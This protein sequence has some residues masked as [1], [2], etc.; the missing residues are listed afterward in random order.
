MIGDWLFKFAEF[1]FKYRKILLFGAILSWIM[2]TLKPYD[3]I[4]PNISSEMLHIIFFTYVCWF[5]AGWLN[6]LYYT[7]RNEFY[8]AGKF[9]LR[10]SNDYTED[11]R[12][13]VMKKNYYKIID[14]KNENFRI[15]SL[16]LGYKDAHDE[17]IRT[18]N[19][20]DVNMALVDDVG[21]IVK[22]L[23]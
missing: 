7:R 22:G 8:L 3:I 10:V 21:N 16:K 4:F 12:I 6:M 20:K 9:I 11:V 15:Y 19:I 2:I 1:V 14:N 13:D 18:G 23:M 17:V 5:I